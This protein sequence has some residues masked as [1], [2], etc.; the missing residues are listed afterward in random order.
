MQLTPLSQS[1]ETVLA[2]VLAKYPK[3]QPIVSRIISAGGQAFLVGGA[4]RDLLMGLAVK[5]LDIEVHNLTIEQLENLLSTFGPVSLV[6]KVR[7][8]QWKR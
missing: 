4:V 8:M 3:V 2:C 5:D 7:M 6:G 1:Q